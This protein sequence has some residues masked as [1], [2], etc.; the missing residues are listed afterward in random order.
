MKP[1]SATANTI[2][3]VQ[4]VSGVL[5]ILGLF[6]FDF[7]LTQILTAVLF[8]YIYS[9]VGIG[10]TLHRYYTHKSFEFIHPAL[11]W[12]FT[13][14]A[15]LAG[16]ASPL[17]WV[18]VHR[19]HH[20]Y[21]DTDKDPHSPKTI[22]FKLFG[23]KHIESK[24]GK[25]NVFLVKDLM[26]KDQIFIHDYYFAIILA[27]LAVVG[28]FGIDMLY[29]TWVLPVFI[30]QLSQNSFNYFAH[31][32]GY[33]NYETKDSSTNNIFLWPLIMGDAWHNNHHGN[34]LGTTTKEKWWEIDPAGGIIRIVKK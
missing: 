7:T 32:V 10:I 4:M 33:R 20:A 16:R 24:S 8:F 28:L 26:T 14:F 23:F 18:Y 1:F 12:V 17:G 27:W 22:G 31:T 13:L 29:F 2:N 30:V 3:N 11:K 15:C 25:M 6:Y 9:I 34:P 5:S 21:S 19:L